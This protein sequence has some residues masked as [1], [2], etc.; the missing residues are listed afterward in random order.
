MPID[1]LKG[2]ETWRLFRILA[3]FVEGF[4]DLND[5]KNGVSIFG[6]ARFKED[7]EY[8]IKAREISKL[9]AE[10]D[11]TIIT[12]GGPG[13]MEA[14]NRGAQDAGKDSVGLNIRLPMEQ[15]P[16]P[17]QTI[18]LD[19]RYFFVRKVM[20]IKY[21]TAYICMPGGFG[22]MDEFFE[23]I[24]L[25][26]TGKIYPMPLILFGSKYWNPV[27]KFMENDMLDCE[28]I[29]KED[30]DLLRVTDDV[31]EVLQIIDDHMKWKESKRREAQL[32]MDEKKKAEIEFFESVDDRL[33]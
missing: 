3:E 26:Q 9:L 18:E 2:R 28:V 32:A 12:G 21:A 15:A 10:N 11:Y 7:H 29:S 27:I 1:D 33:K 19:F 13:I 16:N 6:S 23:A 5:V 8:Y 25:I 14:A 22:T 17:Y 4:E 31:D 30:R 24:T 20:F